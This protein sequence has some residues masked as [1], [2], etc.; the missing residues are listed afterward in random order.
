MKYVVIVPDGMADRPLAELGN[1]TPLEVART[2]NMDYLAKNGR[3]GMVKTIPDRFE[4]GSDIGNLALLGYR[5]EKYFSGRAPLEAANHDIELGP[6]E[7][8]FRCNLITVVDGKMIDYSAG[9]IPTEQADQL[10]KALNEQMDLAGGRFVTGKSYRH[11]LILSTRDPKSYLKMKS[12]PAHDILGQLVSRHLPKGPAS[13]PLLEI[14]EKA[15]TILEN[16]QVNQVRLDL[17]ENPANSIWLWGQGI[18]PQFPGFEEKFGVKGAIIS[19]VDLVNG[20]GKLIG[21]KVIDV[22][23]ITGYYDTDYRAKAEYA[24]KALKSRDYVYIHVEAPDEAG[25]N[26]DIKEKIRAIENIDREI[27]GRIIKHFER[28]QEVRILVVPDHPTPIALR[29]HSREPVGFVMYGK[30]ILPDGS[31]VYHEKAAKLHG[32][33]FKSGEALIQALMK[34]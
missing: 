32:L 34:H 5:P 17:K 7:V 10:I 33:Q 4:P 6:S 22:P 25:H 3:T 27:V 30:G 9:H 16:H 1:K 20:I 21:L 23:G 2:K 13:Q 19:A 8:A 24:I 11:L 15:R 26:G 12:V 18:R 14:M 29:R 31:I 28:S